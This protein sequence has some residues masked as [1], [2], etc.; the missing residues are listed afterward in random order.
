MMYLQ[1]ESEGSWEV[2]L[3]YKDVNFHL[4]VWTYMLDKCFDK[5][6]FH[7][8]QMKINSGERERKNYFLF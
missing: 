6:F 3:D 1:S 4:L 5:L 2:H 7:H 8:S